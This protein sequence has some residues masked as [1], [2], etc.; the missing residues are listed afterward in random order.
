MKFEIL[1]DEYWWGGL[2]HF[3]DKMP[4]D[5]STVF[6]ADL[7]RD[8]MTQSAPLFLSSKGRYLWSEESFVIEFN[9]GV[10]TVE[11]EH[12]VLLVEAGETLREAYLLW[13]QWVL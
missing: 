9:K 11:S 6:K 8:K 7:E 10:I 13:E 4:F 1:K 5:S 12:E 3:A 2:I